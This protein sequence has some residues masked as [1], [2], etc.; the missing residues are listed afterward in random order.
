MSAFGGLL[1]SATHGS[2]YWWYS[3]A[4]GTVAGVSSP[5]GPSPQ[6]APPCPPGPNGGKGTIYV[7]PSGH[8]MTKQGVPVSGATVTL[9][10]SATKNGKLKK[11]PN[12]SAVMS[13]ANRINPSS[14]TLLGSFGWD[15]FPGY[16]RV[17]AHRRGCTAAK[18]T[19]TTAL[20]SRLTVPPAALGLTLR[21]GC[22]KLKRVRTRLSLTV[23]HATGSPL[24]LT[25]SVRLRSLAKDGAAAKAS[26]RVG[27]VSFRSG[28]R[29]LGEIPLDPKTGTALVNLLR[30]TKQGAVTA[31]F[32][33]NGL[34]DPAK[35]K[36]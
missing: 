26:A 16:Y 23:R 19:G 12:H 2:F 4:Q 21:L 9:E 36:G 14:T 5:N 31:S 3:V 17:E 30:P 25:L 20:S 13:P 34:L 27:V 8:V 29:L 7:D 32:A 18:G 11:V 6:P 1:N 35:A 10:R 24:E 33:G 22:P 28:G 15:V